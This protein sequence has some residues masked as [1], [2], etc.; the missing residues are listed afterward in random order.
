MNSL[1]KLLRIKRVLHF[2]VGHELKTATKFVAT[3]LLQVQTGELP[4]RMYG[5]EGQVSDRSKSVKKN[6]FPAA[7]THRRVQSTV[8]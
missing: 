6:T 7:L 3:K 5:T 2:T 8:V 1:S 4:Y